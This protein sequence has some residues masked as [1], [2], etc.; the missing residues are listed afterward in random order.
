[1]IK[2]LFYFANTEAE[3]LENVQNVAP[4]TIVFCKDTNTIWRDG[5]RYGGDNTVVR[6]DEQSSSISYAINDS[7]TEHPTNETDW[8]AERPAGEQG[9]YL[10]TRDIT[11]YTDGTHTI[12]YGVVYFPLDGAGTAIDKNNT[13]VRYS[14]QKT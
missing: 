9:R 12:T 5:K 11:A 4:Y 7:S 3:Y 8:V 14:N 2:T 6:I 13:F 10:W 1:M